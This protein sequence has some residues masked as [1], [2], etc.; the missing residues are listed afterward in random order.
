[1]QPQTQTIWCNYVFNDATRARFLEAAA[2]HR[3]IFATKAGA[4]V[5]TASAP[6]PALREA[7]I[8]FGQPDP[9]TCLDGGRLRWIALTSAGYTRYDTPAFMDALKTGGI[10]F[11]NASS[12]FAEPCAQHLLA[13]M[14]A[15][16]REL[17]PAHAE[18]LGER[19]WKFLEVRRRCVLLNGQTVV[20][21]G[22][23]A[24][25]RRLVELL[26]PFGMKIY[27]VRRRAYSERG[28]H[29][30]SEEKLT[31]V[32]AEA[33]HVVNVLPDNAATLNYVNARRLSAVK[34]G[35]RFYNIGR[36]TTVDNRALL[37]ALGSGRIGGAY[38]D[39]FEQEPL[40]PEHP[41]W[42]A[43]NCYITPHS[44]GGRRD[45]DE[46]IADHF[47]KNLRVFEAGGEGM[48]DR[49]V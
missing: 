2:P 40:P 4:S 11:T 45:Q 30:I 6:D 28:V 32:L 20:L 22:Y 7:T 27:A 42:S 14:L 41:L 3:V 12:V 36:G 46:A 1:M 10:A 49:V 19:G 24:I 15:F 34:P 48:F 21:L 8:A 29:V 35:A 37:E 39:V 13:M 25:A 23:G 33:D 18:Q 38:L 9:A 5:L 26:A 16:A 44:A 47:L 31:A 17:L 43:P